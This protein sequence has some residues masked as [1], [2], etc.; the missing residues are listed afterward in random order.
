M[1]EKNK[2]RN[3]FLDMLKGILILI[4]VFR[5][6]F[7]IASRN[8]DIDYLC[9]LMAIIEMPLFIAIS[10]YFCLPELNCD[11]TDF[12]V[13]NKLKKITISYIIPFFSFYII[14]RLFFYR[15]YN[16]LESIYR[17]FFNIS[18]SLWYLFA[19]WMLNV[20]STIAYVISRKVK[21]RKMPRFVMFCI[22]YFV[23]VG[24]LLFAGIIVNINFLG[25]KLIVYYSVFYIAGYMFMN[26]QSLILLLYK[27]FDHFVLFISMCIYF[28]GGFIFKIM[29]MPDNLVSI[30][31]RFILAIAGIVFFINFTYYIF[32]KEKGNFTKKIG[33]YTLEIYYVH[34]FLMNALN[35]NKALTLFSMDGIINTIILTLFVGIF[36]PL[37]IVIVRQS[38]IAN[39]IVFGKNT[40]KV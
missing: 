36:C 29:S 4:V 39:L 13:I 38:K 6:I 23:F 25:C 31:I 22:L 17:I 34:S 1:I 7:Q 3:A 19:I 21:S 9:N 30:T 16:G 40:Y 26:Y 24:I 12:S 35:I 2:K 32:S 27:K 8:S 5:H 11:L 33:I 37:I 14:F 28:I 10:G 20:F 15:Q 18:Q